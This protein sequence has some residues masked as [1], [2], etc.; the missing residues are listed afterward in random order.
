VRDAA[1]A[2]LAACERALRGETD[3]ALVREAAAALHEVTG[4]PRAAQPASTTGGR[5]ARGRRK[6]G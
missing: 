4:G 3:S 1:A 6:D 5:R 2:A